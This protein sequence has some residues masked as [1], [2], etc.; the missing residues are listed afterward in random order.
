MSD[1]FL[2][3][4]RSAVAAGWYTILIAVIWMTASW[5]VFQIVMRT[6]PD[7]VLSVW[8]IKD[9]DWPIAQVIMLCFFGMWKLILFVGVLVVIWLTLWQRRLRRAAG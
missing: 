2:K 5:G 9:V 8:G 3:G 4:L 1:D 7:W 6:C